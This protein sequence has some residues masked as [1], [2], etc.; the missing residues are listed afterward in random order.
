[1]A[2]AA[3]YAAAT[4]AK[5]RQV[6]NREADEQKLPPK[7]APISLSALASR[8]QQA[9]RNKGTKTYKPF[10]PDILDD[11]TTPDKHESSIHDSPTP[12]PPAPPYHGPPSH[13]APA[14]AFDQPVPMP[15]NMPPVLMQARFA[16]FH[17]PLHM[18][19]QES[20]SPFHRFE[21][22]S[23]GSPLPPPRDEF[24]GAPSLF[25]PAGFH[26]VPR[27][28]LYPP[29]TPLH[30]PPTNF[31]P[32]PPSAPYPI[33][34][35][36]HHQIA[37]PIR[38]QTVQ[39]TGH[40]FH[41]DD[42]SPTKQEQ[43][44]AQLRLLPATQPSHNPIIWQNNS[45]VDDDYNE[46]NSQAGNGDNALNKVESISAATES[47][48]MMSDMDRI[49]YAG[50][51]KASDRA[52]RLDP[53]SASKFAHKPAEVDDVTKNQFRSY[54]ST[55]LTDST[56]AALSGDTGTM[57]ISS[58]ANSK[59]LQEK[60]SKAEPKYLKGSPS[61]W[62]VVAPTDAQ[63]QVISKLK[64]VQY[65]SLAEREVLAKAI[66]NP[67]PGLSPPDFNNAK[68]VTEPE[69]AGKH[70]GGDYHDVGSSN[71]CKAKAPSRFERERMQNLMRRYA[72]EEG[73]LPTGPGLVA[74]DHASQ[75]AQGDASVSDM[76]GRADSRL[77][78]YIKGLAK[79]PSK[80]KLKATAESQNAQAPEGTDDGSVANQVLG[81]VI[82]NIHSYLDP[83]KP[84]GDK[85]ELVKF[86]PI[87]EYAVERGGGAIGA[88]RH[89][90][91]YFDDTRDSLQQAPQRIARDPRFRPPESEKKGPVKDIW[92]TGHHG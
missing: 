75:V 77:E 11:A 85:N 90:Q 47:P 24:Y 35:E 48:S 12:L 50:R 80:D 36:E 92:R 54:D 81:A 57:D 45:E 46:E 39:V 27:P 25:P 76:S 88:P 64:G 86:K 74:E 51:A 32:P 10:T 67:A 69:V 91:S 8:P 2:R 7:Q 53:F 62:G 61:P 63:R 15:S 78:T 6:S 66:A 1:M 9:S 31:P 40:C 37:T 34:T 71:W 23:G 13:Y 20:G 52:A 87:P 28:M 60:T 17:H 14:R 41:P 18:V 5:Q 73:E 82:L 4:N 44:F 21:F 68:H 19:F 29:T 49:N 72:K 56:A 89:S 59:R 83:N 26:H 30:A 84:T 42:L 22:P 65:M 16:G 55:T 58:G 33:L 38:R 43:K 3:E 70:L 79:Q